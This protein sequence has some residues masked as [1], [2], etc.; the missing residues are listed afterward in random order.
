MP[1]LIHKSELIK[2]IAR[3]WKQQYWSNSGW[4]NVVAINGKTK[5]QTYNQL[6]RLKNPTE[7]QITEIIGN[8]SWT[9]NECHQCG[10]DVLMVV[11]VGQEPDWESHTARL[12]I[13]CIEADLKLLKESNAQKE[14]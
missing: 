11:E 3:N 8:S 4:N 6:Q 14:N 13:D 7:E 1:Q 5:E 12:C 9:Q 10:R 2:N